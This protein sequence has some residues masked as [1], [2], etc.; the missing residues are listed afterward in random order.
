M[1]GKVRK[2]LTL[3]PEVVEALGADD[4]ALSATVN[5]ILRSEVERRQRAMALAGLLTRLEVERGPV[6]PDEVEEFRN[7]LR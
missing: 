3:D 7:L 1:K 4:V 2:T 6:D 5:E